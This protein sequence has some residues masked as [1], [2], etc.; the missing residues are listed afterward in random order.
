MHNT[1][2]LILQLIIHDIVIPCLFTELMVTDGATDDITDG[3]TDDITD[4][5]PSSSSSD[6]A[7][8]SDTIML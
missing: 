7:S 1:G 8:W 4:D 3:A 5:V 6:V 2:L